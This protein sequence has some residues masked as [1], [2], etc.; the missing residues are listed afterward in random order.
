MAQAAGTEAKAKA[1]AGPRAPAASPKGKASEMKQKLQAALRPICPLK[2][3]TAI[4]AIEYYE[5]LFGFAEPHRTNTAE[6]NEG[7]RFGFD[8]GINFIPGIRVEQVATESG[9]KA[10]MLF[11]YPSGPR[12]QVGNFWTPSASMLEKQAADRAARTGA[13]AE[14]RPQST[15][16]ADVF[17]PGLLDTDAGYLVS[18]NP[19]CTMQG[20][21]QLNALEQVSAFDH[22]HGI[23]AYARDNTQGPAV[24]ITGYPGALWRQHFVKINEDGTV[25]YPVGGDSMPAVGQGQSREKQVNYFEPVWREIQEK[26]RVTSYA[27]KS[28]AYGLPVREVTDLLAKVRTTVQGKMLTRLDIEN[29]FVNHMRV[30]VQEDTVYTGRR[31]VWGCAGK[32]EPCIIPFDFNSLHEN[33]ERPILSTHV[34]ASGIPF[35]KWD[36]FERAGDFYQHFIQAQY[37]ATFAAAYDNAIRHNY[38][39]SS[40]KLFLEGLGMGAWGGAAAADAK[41]MFF[42]VVLNLMGGVSIDKAIFDGHGYEHEISISGA[43]STAA[44][45]SAAAAF[46]QET[47]TPTDPLERIRALCEQ[48][49]EE[50]APLTPELDHAIDAGITLYGAISWDVAHLLCP[51][52]PELDALHAHAAKSGTQSQTPSTTPQ[53]PV[54]NPQP[55]LLDG[56]LFFKALGFEKP[57]AELV[58]LLAA[59]VTDYRAEIVAW[60]GTRGVTQF[61][62]HV[63]SPKQ[64][65]EELIGQA[66][67]KTCGKKSEKVGEHGA[68]PLTLVYVTN[69]HGTAVAA[70]W[71]S[72]LFLA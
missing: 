20:D 67:A 39:A 25:D 12:L 57:S 32:E 68:K 48:H 9:E 34:Y 50:L 69:A 49:K 15:F 61:C 71:Q 6:N 51:H 52:C 56:F 19:L 7:L 66:G 41:T 8:N 46:V 23:N 2:E 72:E 31:G 3:K 47:E 26:A 55:Q 58:H 22:P 36:D 4:S 1:K 24:A 62:L 27:E 63:H 5:N 64:V 59:E 45:F 17:K 37:R 60:F 35:P 65:T 28:A 14:A 29:M 10:E 54:T 70:G 16:S 11:L 21:S 13:S 30:G 43:R 53:T 42:Y 33:V 40:R 44:V 18:Q 38:Q